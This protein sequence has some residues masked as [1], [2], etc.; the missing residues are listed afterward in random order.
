MSDIYKGRRLFVI[1]G[2]LMLCVFGIYN[3][4][5][6]SD[7]TNQSIK[8]QIRD[9]ELAISVLAKLSVSDVISD[10]KYSRSYFGESWGEIKGCNTRDVILYRD[11]SES[12]VDADCLV[13]SGNLTDPYTGK[14]IKFMRG[15][16]TSSSVQIDHVVALSDAWKKGAYKMSQSYREAF[17]N[18]PLELLA[19]DGPENIKKSDSDASDW[20]PKNISYRC[21]Y[22]SRQIAVK[23]KYNLWIS[24]REA[25]T[26]KNVLNKCPEQRLPSR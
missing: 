5:L 23:F 10:Q 15:K 1:L 6:A 18:D 26:I 8:S 7:N 19:V 13:Q 2:I 12:V 4:G 14:L 16:N 9:T 21:E 22:V 24:Y 20:L 11:L 17:A 25:Q 3:Y